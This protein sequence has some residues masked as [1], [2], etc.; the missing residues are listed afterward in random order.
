MALYWQHDDPP[1]ML[2]VCTRTQAEQLARFDHHQ[3]IVNDRWGILITYHW[4]PVEM[5]PEPLIA[6]VVFNPAPEHLASEAETRMAVRNHPF[7]PSAI[8]TIIGRL[9]FHAP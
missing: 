7:A 9:A 5:A 4:M 3:V 1:R 8:Q 2:A 6:T